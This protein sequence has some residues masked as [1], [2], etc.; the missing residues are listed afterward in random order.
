MQLRN[1]WSYLNLEVIADVATVE[2]RADQLEF[3][4]KE[5]LCVPVLVSD[6]VKD[7][8]IVGHG[9]NT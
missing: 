5:S 4:V 8:L 9:V 3:P 7:L 6:K 2:L 1:A